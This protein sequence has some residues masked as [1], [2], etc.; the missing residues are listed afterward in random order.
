MRAAA[1]IPAVLVA[2]GL[3]L[4]VAAV[5]ALA[6]I[7]I[8]LGVLAISLAGAIGMTVTGRPGGELV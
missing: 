2:I 5:F 8:G 4:A 3:F 1:F 7:W 6:P